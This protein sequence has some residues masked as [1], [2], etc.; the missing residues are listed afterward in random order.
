METILTDADDNT[1]NIGE[2]HDIRKSGKILRRIGINTYMDKN[3][4]AGILMC[5][6]QHWLNHK[7]LFNDDS[8]HYTVEQIQHTE[9]IKNSKTFLRKINLTNYTISGNA[10]LKINPCK[11]HTATHY[12]SLKISHVPDQLYH[13]TIIRLKKHTIWQAE[14]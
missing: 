1:I 8:D 10:K 5:K 6:K 12:K 9:I 4:G 7:K 2:E 11:Y 13:T 3:Q 14:L